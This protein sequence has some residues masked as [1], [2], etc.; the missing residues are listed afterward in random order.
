VHEHH[1]GVAGVAALAPA[2]PA[3]RHHEHPGGQQAAEL[4]II[5]QHRDRRG[6]PQHQAA[7]S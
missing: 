7:V 5:T 1:V 2:A 3:H 6:R 4:G